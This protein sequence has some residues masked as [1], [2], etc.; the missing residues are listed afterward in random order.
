MAYG[1]IGL[2]GIY[3]IFVG[4]KGNASTF[5]QMVSEDGPGFTP[6]LISI[7]VLGTAYRSD[8]LRPVVKPFIALLIL[9]FVL[10]NWGALKSQ[11][12]Q[13]LGTIGMGGNASTIAPLNGSQ[14]A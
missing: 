11:T 1:L 3:L 10:K 12:Q 2:Y 8:T 4:Y 14:G 9:A 13:V 5:M 7:V 6:W